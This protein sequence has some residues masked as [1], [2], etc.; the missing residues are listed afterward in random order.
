MPFK[1]GFYKHIPQAYEN[2]VN[3]MPKLSKHSYQ[4]STIYIYMSKASAYAWFQH[5]CLLRRTIVSSDGAESGKGW[6]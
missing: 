3:T 5:K 1:V 6:Q 4:H 2:T